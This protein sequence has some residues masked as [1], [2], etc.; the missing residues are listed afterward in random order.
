MIIMHNWYAYNPSEVSRNLVQKISQKWFIIFLRYFLYDSYTFSGALL[1]PPF[2]GRKPYTQ[3]SMLSYQNRKEPDS[4]KKLMCI[5]V[6]CSCNT[7]VN[8]CACMIYS[9]TVHTEDIGIH[10]V[11]FTYPMVFLAKYFATI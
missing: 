8:H 1:Q 3:N 7:R 5:N 4:F 6:F 2:N 11:L 9:C 10:S